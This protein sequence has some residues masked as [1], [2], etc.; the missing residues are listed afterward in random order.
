MAF[1]C[2][3]GFCIN[4]LLLLYLSQTALSPHTPTFT[5]NGNL[6]S[7]PIILHFQNKPVGIEEIFIKKYH[8]NHLENVV[9][10]CHIFFLGTPV[11]GYGNEERQTFS[12]LMETSP[13]SS[14]WEM[15]PPLT[16]SESFEVGKYF[17]VQIFFIFASLQSF[18]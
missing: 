11:S 4:L 16:S 5:N 12:L 1:W 15:S 13:D 8:F 17:N 2:S 14:Q 18:A 10:G 7:P 3:R 9:F 6:A